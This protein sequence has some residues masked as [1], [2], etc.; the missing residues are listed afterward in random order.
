MAVD[1]TGET[2]KIDVQDI[3]IN[4]S[5]CVER[6]VLSKHSRLRELS[7]KEIKQELIPN[8]NSFSINFGTGS[9]I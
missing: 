1:C 6:F 7:P 8:S 4:L 2:S 9:N 3:Q 5:N